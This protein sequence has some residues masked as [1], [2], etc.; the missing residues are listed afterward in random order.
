[1]DYHS[2]RFVDSSLLIFEGENLVGCFPASQND[3]VR[4]ISH[5][6]LTYGGIIVDK[7][8]KTNDL[9]SIFDAIFLEYKSRGFVDFV[10]KVT[11]SF[12]KKCLSS[13][14][15]YAL[16]RSGAILVGRGMSTGIEL[17]NSEFPKKKIRDLRNQINNALIF[18]QNMEFDELLSEINKN[19]QERYEVTAVH[20]ADEISMLSNRFPENIRTFCLKSE[21]GSLY[22]GIIVYIVNKVAHVQ[23][24]INTDLGKKSRSLDRLIYEVYLLYKS[25]GLEWLE[26]GI[27]TTDGGRNLNSGLLGYK[28]G[29][30]GAPLCYDTYLLNF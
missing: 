16:F 5:G 17:Q 24:M 28:E 11:P 9:L 22:A 19:L 18:C 27:S 29:F 13:A 21:S 14:E 2:D 20:T 26:F 1:M 8:T 23:Y 6:G 25:Q 3:R 30:G 4:V 15:E 7:K 10:Y 12:Y